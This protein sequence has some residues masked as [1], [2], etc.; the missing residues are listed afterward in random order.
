MEKPLKL[1]SD[2]APWYHLL[3][4]PD[5]YPEEAE[6]YRGVILSHCTF[7]PRTLLE[8]GSGGGNNASHM[9]A[10]FTM[11]LTDISPQ[12]L[13]LSG[14]LNPECEHVPGDMRSIRLQRKF[15]AVFI[16]DAICY[17]TSREDLAR[18]IHTAFVHLRPGGVVLLAPDFVTETFKPYTDHGGHDGEGR[19]LRYL[20][21]VWDPDP[22]DSIYLGEMAYLLRDES[23]SVHMYHD[24]HEEGLFPQAA[25]LEIMAEQGFRALT[26][27]FEH[28]DALNFGTPVFVGIKPVV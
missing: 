27:P 14:E 6:F 20:E 7:P 9:K 16:H 13:A 18:A 5:E 10:H 12:M 1:Y 25:W 28:S 21:W 8:L 2:L 23:G 11:T 15:D 4:H 19:A 26:V 3:T 24:R 22:S 17:M